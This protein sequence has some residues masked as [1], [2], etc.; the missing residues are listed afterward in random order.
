MADV[1]FIIFATLHIIWW[2]VS[3]IIRAVVFLVSPI[4]LLLSFILLPFIHLGHTIINVVTFPFSITWLDRIETV[5]VFLGT[6]GL[7]GCMTGALV[8]IIFKF[9]SSTL[10]IDSTIVPQPQRQGRTTADYRA[11]WREKKEE[12]M[13]HSPLSSPIVLR[14]VTG[15]RR[16]GLLSQAIIEEEDSDF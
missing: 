14:K 16:R 12:Q 4:W 9:V 5:Y 3:Q 6:A 10:N 13:D 7:I 11:A 1:R 15:S 2:P 8:F